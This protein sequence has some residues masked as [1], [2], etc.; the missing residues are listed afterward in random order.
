MTWAKG[1]ILSHHPSKFTICEWSDRL[2]VEIVA[3]KKGNDKV[4]RDGGIPNI[5]EMGNIKFHWDREHKIF[6]GRGISNSPNNE[7]V[8]FFQKWRILNFPRVRSMESSEERERE[9]FQ[10][11]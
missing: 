11:W 2:C 10:R 7:N 9:I 8:R 5:R 4:S 1:E 6:Q 3:T